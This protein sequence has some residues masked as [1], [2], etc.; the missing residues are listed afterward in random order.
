MTAITETTSPSGVHRLESYDYDLPPDRIAQHPVTPRDASRLLSMDRST[1]ALQDLH[2][3]DLAE[4]LNE[5]DV[6][7]LNNTRVIPGTPSVRSR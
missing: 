3:R 5:D 1:G 6:L 4:L 2:F 7:V